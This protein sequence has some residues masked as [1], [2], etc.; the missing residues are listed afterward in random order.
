MIVT[1]S[2]RRSIGSGSL[3][4]F[5]AMRRASSLVSRLVAARR[6]GSSLKRNSRALVYDANSSSKA[7]A[8]FRSSVSKPSVN[9]P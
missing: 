1:R 6:S 3:A 9:Q 2:F 4:K 7:F 5:T 8:S